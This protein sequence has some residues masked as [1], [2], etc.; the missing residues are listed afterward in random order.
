[1][2]EGS[3]LPPLTPNVIETRMLET[4]EAAF[5]SGLTFPRET[6]ASGQLVAGAPW[7]ITWPAVKAVQLELFFDTRQVFDL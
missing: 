1:M 3:V 7:S 5:Q 6:D 2:P 4:G